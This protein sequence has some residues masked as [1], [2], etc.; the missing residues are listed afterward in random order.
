MNKLNKQLFIRKLAFLVVVLLVLGIIPGAD[1]PILFGA[2]VRGLVGLVL[3]AELVFGVANWFTDLCSE[4]GVATV[5]K[6]A[7][8]KAQV[9]QTWRFLARTF[10]WAFSHAKKQVK[11]EAVEAKS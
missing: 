10:V 7:N 6:T 11:V 9:S 5:A 3:S 8:Q 2:S 4:E 1:V